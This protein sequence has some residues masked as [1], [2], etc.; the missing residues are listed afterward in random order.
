MNKS[1]QLAIE[2]EV[3]PEVLSDSL[4]TNNKQSPRFSALI[5]SQVINM[6]IHGLLKS[7]ALMLKLKP[8]FN[9]YLLGVDGYINFSIVFKTRD[10]LIYKG[11]RF[12]EGKISIFNA[13][14]NTGSS[15]NTREGA[16]KIDAVLTCDNEKALM[17]IFLLP[18]NEALN[19]ILKNKVYLEGNVVYL[20]TF[21][22]FVSL[23]M[24]NKHQ[25]LLEKSQ[26]EDQKEREKSYGQADKSLN[27]AETKLNAPAKEF[28]ARP[29]Y[30]MKYPQGVNQDLAVKY[31]A[32]AYLSNY[33][34]QDFPRLKGFLDD[35]LDNKAEVCA[36]RA[37]LFTDYYRAN[38]FETDNQGN[39]TIPQLRQANAYKYVM[40]N[41][42]AIIR[43][44]DLLAGTTSSNPTAGCVVYPDAQGTM[45]WGELF[46]IDKRSLIPC[47]ISEE[48]INTLHFDVFPFWAERNFNE[49]VRQEQGYRT[50][51]KINERWV[52]YFVWKSVGISHTVPDFERLLTKGNLGTIADID[53][54]LDKL[55]GL[56]NPSNSSNNIDAINSLTAMKLTLQGVNNYAENLAQEALSQAEQVK[57][58][59][60][61][62]E[63]TKL[64]AICKK[65]P[66]SPPDTLDEAFNA[67]WINW[68]GLHNENADTGLSFGRLDQLLQPYFERDM[69]KLKTAQEREIYTAHA[70]DLAGCFFMRATDHFPLGPD[71]ANFLF[72]GAS[73]TQALTLGGITKEGED[74]VND[75]TYI[76]LKVTEMLAIRDV[77]VNARFNLEKNSNAYLDRLCEVNFITAGTPSMHNDDAVFASLK[78]HGYPQELIHDWSATG[79]VE[80]SISGK[81]MGHTGSILMNLV[82]GLEMVLNDGYH[83]LMKWQLG[84]NTGSVESFKTFEDFYD[85]YTQQQF[86]LIDQAIELNNGLAKVHAKYRP[87]PLLSA[88]MEGSIEN[89]KDVTQGGAR[90][91]SSGVSNI[92][93]ADV[94]DSL[95]VVKKLVFDDNSI[96]FKQLKQALDTNFEND[97]VLRATIKNKIAFFGSGDESAIA[98][99]NKV[100]AT[101]QRY[102]HNSRNYRDGPYTAG[103]WSMSQHVAY[104]SLSGALPSGRLSGKAFT[105]GL[106]PQPCASKNFLDNIF[107]VAKLAPESM[108]NN[109]AFNVKLIPDS[110]DTREETVNTMRSYVKT[111]FEHGGMQMQFNVVTSETLRDA[112]AHPENY[113][114]L[115]VR[116]SGYN[117][118][119]TTLNKDI[120]IELIERT[121][122]GL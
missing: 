16:E 8:S 108:D 96:S 27:G 35:H 29:D 68:V 10:N 110:N 88:L 46:A 91:N 71:I 17:D 31:L 56:N 117:A 119:F 44:G 122:Y 74:A 60:R 82:A 94:T 15:V 106:T 118:Y 109:I 39:E 115:L 23:I 105:P 62:D 7:I 84:P 103:F 22:F 47:D 76:F 116:I 114:N 100:A 53:L 111:Y 80:P 1:T 3:L 42:R 97:A 64:A 49:W 5:K 59:E 63:L 75:M 89:G 102:Y 12:N 92:G 13:P 101:F 104:G 70:I 11:I 30:R 93:L 19:L 87:T 40:E 66:M 54:H 2:A 79:C 26:L 18:P 85:A 6:G 67:I 90:F 57:G 52:A 112:M 43:K 24:K 20:Q 72:G 38:G 95:L 81:H 55:G 50:S 33:S 32:D 58:T 107:D 73:S 120:Q 37:K 48:T 4:L 69:A 45:I 113:K 61:Y 121:E 21:N 9:K 28:K 25:K 99:A 83:P 77:N 51:Q 78:P 86:F 34:L 36:E 65:V 14:G 98:M 41:K